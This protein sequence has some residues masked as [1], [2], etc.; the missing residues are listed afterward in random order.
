MSAVG[1]ILVDHLEHLVEQLFVEPTVEEAQEPVLVVAALAENLAHS[2]AAV[3]D[4]E[5]E[6]DAAFERGLDVLSFLEAGF[7][8]VACAV[9]LT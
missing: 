7:Q 5:K 2:A 9:A 1:K 3:H 4:G 6:V 8:V